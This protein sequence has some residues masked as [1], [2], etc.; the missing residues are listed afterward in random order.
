MGLGEFVVIFELLVRQLIPLLRG[1]V[2]WFG[3]GFGHVAG[4]SPRRKTVGDRL[5]ELGNPTVAGSLVA[6]G[7]VSS[8]RF[9]RLLKV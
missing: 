5:V 6:V 7:G 2:A 1:F 4:H 8:F 9:S 3:L